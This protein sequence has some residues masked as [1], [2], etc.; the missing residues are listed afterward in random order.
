[1]ASSVIADLQTIALQAARDLAG[2]DA[3]EQVDVV[4][5][6]NSFDEPVYFVSFLIDPARSRERMGL[7]YTRMVQKLSNHLAALGD[8]RSPR[9]TLL[10]RRDWDKRRRA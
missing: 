1:M 5:G 8:E 4:P 10:D 6:V 9:I 7:V 3:V 2:D